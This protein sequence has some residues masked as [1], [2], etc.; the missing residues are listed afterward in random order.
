[1][2]VWIPKSAGHSL[3]PAKLFGD[4]VV[5]FNEW[6]TPFNPALLKEEV[7]KKLATF[8]DGDFL[9]LSGPVLLNVIVVHEILMRYGRVSALLYHSR[10]GVY[11]KREIK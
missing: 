3:E 1:M 9:L 11:L 8:E 7:Q 6:T 5:M 2:K 4:L 10:D